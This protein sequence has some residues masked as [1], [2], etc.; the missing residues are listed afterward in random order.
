MPKDTVIDMGS[1]D[2]DDQ[3]EKKSNGSSSAAAVEDNDESTPLVSPR[4][5]WH[6]SSYRTEE[7]SSRS[8]RASLRPT[9][10][11]FKSFRTKRVTSAWRESKTRRQKALEKDGVGPAAFLIR[12]AFLGLLENPSEGAYNPYIH[13]E[14]PIINNIAIF[15][16]RLSSITPVRRILNWTI[17]LLV[18]VTFVEPPNWCLNH[19]I[20]SCDAVFLLKGPAAEN[21]SETVQYYPNTNTNYLTEFQ[22]VV[23]ESFLVSILW[24][25]L[26]ICIGRDG[27]SVKRYYRPGGAQRVRVVETFALT[28]LTMGIIADFATGFTCPRLFAPY[29]RLIILISFSRKIQ[30]EIETMFRLVSVCLLDL[31][32]VF[33]FF[34]SHTRCLLLQGFELTNVIILLFTF[35]IFY[36]WIGVVLFY[37]QPEGKQYFPNLID[38]VWTLWVCVTTAIY[39]DVMMPSYNTNRMAALYF[40]FFMVVTYFFLMNIIL[41][42]VVSAYDDELARR[43]QNLTDLA[44]KN[45]KA[46]FQLMDSDETGEIDRETV[47]ALFYVLNED[48][49]EF[50]TIPDDEAAILFAVLDSDGSC[51][52]ELDEFLE[53]GNVMLLEFKRKGPHVTVIEQYMPWL[54]NTSCFQFFR[55]SVQSKGFEV[56]IDVIVVMYAVAVAYS[57]YPYLLGQPGIKVNTHALDGKID[58]FW[59]KLDLFLVVLYIVELLFKLIIRGWKQFSS[60]RKNMFDVTI[61]SLAALSTLYVYSPTEYKNSLLIRY[62]VMTRVLRLVRWWPVFQTIARVSTDVLARSIN[63][64][65][66]LFCIA[67][68]FADL[69]VQVFGGM[70][71]RDP[72]NP[73][74]LL[75]A[76][77]LFASSN[78]WGN[79]FNDMVSAMNV[80]FNLLVVN[81]WTECYA[82]FEAVAQNQWPRLYFLAFFLVGVVLANNLVIAFVINAFIVEWNLR[83]EEMRSDDIITGDG[84]IRG[85][86]AELDVTQVTGTQTNLSGKYVATVH[87]RQYRD[88]TDSHVLHSLLTQSYREGDS[89]RSDPGSTRSQ[90]APYSVRIRP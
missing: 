69:G 77:S 51:S 6:T 18:M 44:A 81:N 31:G 22:A 61:T 33:L 10:D 30:R 39:P 52:I 57:S 16:H 13:P 71:S 43:R 15:C 70:I 62:L 40:I 8:F 36:A 64:L 29:W 20:G 60:S 23:V 28:M 19:S 90:R 72:N 42:T 56:F 86:T 53:F 7:G 49:P 38:G 75:L 32:F 59:E 17:A 2:N 27:L 66:L 1:S 80:M 58:T 85:H 26:L 25:Y 67:Y 5:S 55:K 83:Q 74:A 24:L 47:M 3:D 50:R 11:R 65:L 68:F 84:V 46:A 82:G 88:D 34:F 37:N 54:Y 9:F 35:I 12:D 21:P 89:L 78:Y 63:M 73:D 45:L 79:N 87:R 48:F 76:D 41:A 14:S 4:V